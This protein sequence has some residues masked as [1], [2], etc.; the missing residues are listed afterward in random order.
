MYKVGDVLKTTVLYTTT[1]REPKCRWFV[2]L[3]RLNFTNNP[4][5]IY[6]CTA[7]TQIQRYKENNS[8]YVFFSE[9]SSCFEKDCII[10]LDEI[11][12]SYTEK[13]FNDRYK[14]EIKGR[15][16]D[17]KLKE[18]ATKIRRADL[19]PKVIGDIVDSFKR[20]GIPTK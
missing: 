7:T 18:I 15:I 2:F 3:G 4:R 5:N 13:E 19:S 17:D 14:P 1:G 16:S 10:C 11:E 12:D 20:D 8:V 6:L 9:H